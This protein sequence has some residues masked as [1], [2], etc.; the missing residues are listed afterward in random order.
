MVAVSIS[1]STTT[2]VAERRA[3]RPAVAGATVLAVGLVAGPIQLLVVR[4]ADAGNVAT[5][6]HQVCIGLTAVLLARGLVVRRS[7]SA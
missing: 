3:R 2:I 5:T 7:T 6:I 1:R 4:G